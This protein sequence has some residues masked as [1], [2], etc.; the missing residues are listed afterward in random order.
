ME[1]R[2]E[3]VNN[4]QNLRSIH[5]QAPIPDTVN[6]TLLCLQ[7]DACLLF[8]ER[9]YQH[10]TQTD[11]ETHKYTVER[12]GGRITSQESNRNS[13]GKATVPT[14]LDPWG[15]LKLNHQPRTC[16]D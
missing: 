12:I 4:R 1:E 3:P 15:S 7:T 2:A 14:N 6:A 10:L 11:T 5:G 9:L 13:T 8:S 16:M